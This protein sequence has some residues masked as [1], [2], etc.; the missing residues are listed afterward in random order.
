MSDERHSDERLSTGI[1]GLDPLLEGGLLKGGVYIIQGPPGAGKT[2]LGNQICAHHAGG[3]GRVVY[4][5]LL[6][7]SH[8]RMLAHLRRM[9]FFSEALI[10]ERLY[11]VSAFKVLEGEGLDGLLRTLRDAIMARRASLIVLD[12]LLSARDASPSEQA[13]KKF[14]H[15]LQTLT[16]M[17]GCTILLLTSGVQPMGADPAHTMVDGILELRD[18]LI[19]LKPTRHLEIRKLRGSAPVRGP[20]TLEISDEGIAVRPRIETQLRRAAA[21]TSV[22]PGPGRMGFGVP[23][24]D[25]MLRSGLPEQSVTMLLG[26]SGTGKTILC[27]QFL[28]E[29]ARRGE[30]G[31]YFGFYERP[32][33]LLR[34]CERIG[35]GLEAGVRAGLIELVR[36]NPVEALVDVF[37]ERLLRAVRGAGAKRLVVDG[38]QEVQLAADFSSRSRDVFSALT[39]ELESLGVT[40]LYTAETEDLFGPRIV[41][42]IRGI[43]AATHNILLLRHAERDGR[44]CRLLSI[45]KVRDSGYDSAVRELSITE[46]GVRLG[47]QLSG[48]LSAA[49]GAR[50]AGRGAKASR[51]R[52]RPKAGRGEGNKGKA[53]RRRR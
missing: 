44:V 24:L 13:F 27:L 16:G 52:I 30:R 6:A 9:R 28:A 14:I 15:E 7:E 39:E 50:A 3:G 12:G 2:I 5:T 41:V 38:M 47:D 26:A 20:H 40:L 17:V 33:S 36:E 10:P 25:E 19:G 32:E 18:E 22:A 8:S 53:G 23:D 1:P 42:P 46:Q 37:C 45:I 49:G 21:P 34:K 43:S 51:P 35:L 4:L 48:G 29:G 11:Y 31:L